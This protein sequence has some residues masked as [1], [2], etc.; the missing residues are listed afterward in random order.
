MELEQTP[1]AAESAGGVPAERVRLTVLA[2]SAEEAAEHLKVL[3]GIQ[4]ESKG[5]CLW[6]K[7]EGEIAGGDRGAESA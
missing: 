2:A 5:K 4:T 3:Q 1:A 6:L 7:L